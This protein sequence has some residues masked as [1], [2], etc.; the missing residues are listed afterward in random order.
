[1]NPS[2]HDAPALRRG[3]TILE[4][5]TAVGIIAVLGTLTCGG[6]M[7]YR[8]LATR[9]V[10][11]NNLREL[12]AAT[13]MYCSDHG[14]SFPPYSQKT[15]QGTMWYFGLESSSAGAGE[16]DRDLD[17]SAGPLYPYIMEVGKIEICPAFDYSNALWK[18]KFQGASYGYGYNW[19]LGGTSGGTPMTNTQLGST[20]QTILFGDCGQV[21]TFQAPASS[22]NPMMEEFYIINQSDKTIHFRHNNHAN[23]LF[24]DGHVESWVPYPG[25][26]DRRIK[27]Q[28]FGRITPVGSKAMLK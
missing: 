11:C 27:G 1:M 26:E 14:G 5:L 10:C 22:A 15:P 12:G 19:F 16:G 3:F 25:T 28:L 20:S 2:V 9:A 21:N 6:W 18:A 24:V 8:G 13:N 7:Y 17:Q 23:I 4:L